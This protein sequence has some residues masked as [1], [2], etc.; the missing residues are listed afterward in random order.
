VVAELAR[1]DDVCASPAAI[2]AGNGVNEGS[3]HHVLEFLLGRWSCSVRSISPWIQRLLDLSTGWYG[4][5]IVTWSTN[6]D[7]NIDCQQI[8]FS[9]RRL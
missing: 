2:A 5:I 8:L 4:I 7:E 9:E 6:L 3:A 1:R